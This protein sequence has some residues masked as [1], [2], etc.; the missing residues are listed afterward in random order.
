MKQ[1]LR[2]FA[3]VAALAAACVAGARDIRDFFIA[4]PAQ[5]TGVVLS[6]SA[7]L[8]MLD[9]FN[10]NL[11]TP[12]SNELGGRSRI[13]ALS[14]GSIEVDISDN[15]KLQMALV[16]LKK[17]TLIAIVE[18]VNTPVPDSN[19]RIYTKDWKAIPVQMPVWTDFVPKNQRAQAEAA[20]EPDFTFTTAAF[21]TGRKV[22]VFTDRSCEYYPASDVPAVL[23]LMKPEIRMTFDGRK[24]V[25][26]K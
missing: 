17:D 2:I 13:T 22:F 12:T 6:K 14:P 25:P 8:D 9:Y 23:S 24:L 26:A 21:D 4:A 7:R 1:C 18:T 19:V 20:D 5:E 11:A 10:S 3:V 16:P 15:T